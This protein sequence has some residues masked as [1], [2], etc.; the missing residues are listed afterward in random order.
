MLI[1]ELSPF[2]RKRYSSNASFLEQYR[3]CQQMI[4]QRDQSAEQK[5]FLQAGWTN[6]NTQ[7]ISPSPKEYLGFLSKW[8]E[9]GCLI[10]LKANRWRITLLKNYRVCLTIL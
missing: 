3:R 7:T 2:F 4:A 5:A 6:F 1:P 8:G 9:K 10:Y